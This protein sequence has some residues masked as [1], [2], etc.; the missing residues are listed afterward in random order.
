MKFVWFCGELYWMVNFVHPFLPPLNS[1]W[2]GFFLHHSYR[3]LLS[4]LE[5]SQSIKHG[6]LVQSSA[7]RFSNANPVLYSVIIPVLKM[8]IRFSKWEPID[9][10]E[11]ENRTENRHQVLT[12]SR[13]GSNIYSFFFEKRTG[14]LIELR[15]GS[16]SSLY[17]LLVPS[18]SSSHLGLL[19]FSCCYYFYELFKM[20]LIHEILI[21][22]LWKLVVVV[23]MRTDLSE[24]GWVWFL[25]ITWSVLNSPK[26]NYIR[27]LIRFS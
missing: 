15:S 19:L 16:H 18:C 20:L 23:Y 25:L 8:P 24:N 22:R 17:H 26:K 12:F 7:G 10:F 11:C 21:I 2:T 6:I 27:E 14:F 4:T 9:T 1:V 13:T 3:C 5:F